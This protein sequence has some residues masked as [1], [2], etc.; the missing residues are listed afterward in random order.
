[1]FSS[2]TVPALVWSTEVR[3]LPTQTAIG[4]SEPS[5]ISRSAIEQTG[6]A[7]P[8]QI[9]HGTHLVRSNTRRDV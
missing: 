9:R 1:M 3:H 8:K 6:A 4:R 2:V 7:E 5:E